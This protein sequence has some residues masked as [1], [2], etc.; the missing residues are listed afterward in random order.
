MK[1]SYCQNVKQH[2]ARKI[3]KLSVKLSML[4]STEELF[5]L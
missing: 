5:S 4:I 1:L 3:Q 2:T